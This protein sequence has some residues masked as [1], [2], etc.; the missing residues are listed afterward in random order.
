MTTRHHTGTTSRR[1]L[2]GAVAVTAALA[3]GCS[4]APAGENLPR[5]ADP[6]CAVAE[7][8]VTDALGELDGV[9]EVDVVIEGDPCGE[10]NVDSY[11]VT[12]TMA[13]DSTGDDLAE[14]VTEGRELFIRYTAPLFADDAD[15]LLVYPG[16]LEFH[17]SPW[18]RQMPVEVADV[19]AAHAETHLVDWDF[20][21]SGVVLADGEYVARLVPSSHATRGADAAALDKLLRPIIG[22]LRE[23]AAAAPTST[24]QFEIVL[25]S[26]PASRA[27]LTVTSSSSPDAPWGEALMDY[28]E[29][30]EEASDVSGASVTIDSEDG[31]ELVVTGWEPLPDGMQERLDALALDLQAL[32]GVVVSTSI[33]EPEETESSDS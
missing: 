22:L 4:A 28:V 11:E 13:E 5:T 20:G 2:A 12:L 25:D 10:E 21:D 17:I 32:T 33:N 6:Q 9:E 1:A 27:W 7:S 29:I 23:V 15:M 19:L 3:V 26:T 30:V 8:L 14:I 24:T 18:T 16:G 31:T